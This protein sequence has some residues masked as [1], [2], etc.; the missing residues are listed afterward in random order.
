[1]KVDVKKINKELSEL[2][3]LIELIESKKTLLNKYNIN[4]SIKH[5]KS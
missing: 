2:F 4:I 3:E 1:M 5:I